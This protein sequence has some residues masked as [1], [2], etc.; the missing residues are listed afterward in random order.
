MKLP[1]YI[2]ARSVV[3]ELRSAAAAMIS[4]QEAAQAQMTKF[5]A[6]AAGATALSDVAAGIAEIQAEEEYTDAITSYESALNLFDQGLD[7]MPL[8]ENELGEAVFDPGKMVAL[9]QD[10][11]REILSSIRSSMKSGA[12]R[13]EFDR[14]VALARPDREAQIAAQ[15]Q[16]KNAVF[17]ETKALGKI[18]N[19]IQ[20]KEYD[21]AR[22]KNDSALTSGAI[23]AVTHAENKQVID[24][25]EELDYFYGITNAEKFD[26]AAAELAITAISQHEL[27]GET[28]SLSPQQLSPIRAK[29]LQRYAANEA[30]QEEMIQD[31]QFLNYLDL[32]DL[33]EKGELTEQG[34]MAAARAGV[35]DPEQ[36]ISQADFER[37]Q[38]DMGE[39]AA[40]KFGAIGDTAQGFDY[41]STEAQELMNGPEIVPVIPY[42]DKLDSEYNWNERYDRFLKDITSPDNGLSYDTTQKLKADVLAVRNQLLADPEYKLIAKQG[43][44]DVTGF[45]P[46]KITAMMSTM[47][48]QFKDTIAIGNEFNIA[49]AKERTRLGPGNLD[50]VAEFEKSQAPIYRLKVNNKLLSKVGVKFTYPKDGV[51]DEEFVQGMADDMVVWLLDRRE[52][53]PGT[54]A[55]DIRTFQNVI[56]ELERLNGIDIRSYM[57]TEEQAMVY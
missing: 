15:M 8:E 19:F 23:G 11:R 21:S 14:Q 27:D 5:G 29:L 2:K 42:T 22:A 10:G 52:A 50:K 54:A 40:D 48:S 13:R 31:A 18:Q 17:V 45:E 4:P 39:A 47:D 16:A 34:L 35:M 3:P 26:P 37:L 25:S 1:R 44:Y 9:E 32:V 43:I 20:A 56:S 36:G 7:A 6:I 30:G 41:F 46:D 57:T 53:N 24:T 33:N 38:G 49:I 51:I 12:A 55:R 28:L